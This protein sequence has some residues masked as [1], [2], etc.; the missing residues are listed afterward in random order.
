MADGA[1]ALW[2][3]NSLG[4]GA[5]VNC[6]QEEWLHQV[7][8]GRCGQ[9]ACMFTSELR[10]AFDTLVDAPEG[11]AKFGHIMGVN[12]MGFSAKDIHSF[13]SPTKPTGDTPQ[14]VKS[15]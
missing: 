15:V 1:D 14:S 9:E 3:G 10:E 6:A 2:R 4:I 13:E 5:V 11:F 7:R 12:F 8:K